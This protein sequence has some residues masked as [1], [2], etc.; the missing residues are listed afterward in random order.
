MTPVVLKL[1]VII[2]LYNLTMHD[3]VQSPLTNN[4]EF[5]HYPSP[6]VRS[7]LEELS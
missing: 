4:H 2:Q 5:S 7:S 1:I 6:G 3:T